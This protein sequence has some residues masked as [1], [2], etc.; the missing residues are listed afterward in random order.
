MRNLFLFASLAFLSVDGMIRADAPEEVSS[1]DDPVIVLFAKGDMGY[2]NFRIPTVVRCGESALVVFC[3]ARAG[4][5]ADQTDLVAR[6]SLDGGQT[7]QPPRVI[8][9]HEQFVPRYADVPV[10]VGNPSP[11]VD[12]LHPSHPD[13]IHLLFTVENTSV[14]AAHSDDVG[15][16]WSSPLDITD[17]T[18]LPAWGWYATGPVHGIQMRSPNYRGRLVVACDH[19]IGDN[20]ADRGPN[21]AHVLY[22]D[23]HGKLWRI[24][25]IDDH[26]DNDMDANETSVAAVGDGRLYFNT[27][28]QLGGSVWTRGDTWSVDGGETFPS[29]HPHYPA[30]VPVAGV[31]DPPIVQCSLWSDAEFV[32]ESSSR[33]GETLPLWFCGPDR[34]GPSGG[35]RQ[36]LRLRHSRS[37]GWRWQDGALI[38]VGPAGYSDMTRLPDGKLG[39]VFEAGERGGS[40]FDTIRWT[41]RSTQK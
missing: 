19:R 38:H 36:D 9:S 33:A 41:S 17:Q 6:R 40:Y 22:S 30:M 3:E 28:D 15:A 2:N 32:A 11:V 20:G 5:D 29:L 37:G 10:T 1:D 31:L 25:A 4:N 23:D 14:H 26:Y 35:G 18:K 21:G 12:R 34:H 39:I 16:S 8:F 13:R 7:W 27:R 24:G